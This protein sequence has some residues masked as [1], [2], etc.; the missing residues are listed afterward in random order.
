M[1]DLTGVGTTTK[2]LEIMIG[3]TLIKYVKMEEALTWWMM[4]Q[5]ET[6]GKGLSK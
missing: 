6:S 5:K 1:Y 2:Y 4:S 3:M